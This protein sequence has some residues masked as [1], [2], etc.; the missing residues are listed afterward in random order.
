MKMCNFF[1]ENFAEQVVIYINVPRY[2]KWPNLPLLGES[3]VGNVGENA[4]KNLTDMAPL[5]IGQIT[6]SMKGPLK[7]RWQSL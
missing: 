2:V 6:T 3:Q 5:W 1:S 7:L 4:V